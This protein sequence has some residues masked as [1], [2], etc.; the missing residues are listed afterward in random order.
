MHKI[1]KSNMAAEK[2]SRSSFGIAMIRFSHN[3]GA[4]IGLAIIALLILLAIFAPMLTKFPYDRID[5][6]N[7]F[8]SPSW[9]H[10]FG[11][12]DLGRD[13]LSRMMYGGR[14]SL[15]IGV[16][17]VIISAVFGI[18]FGSVAGYFGG[19]LD[20]VIMRF[21][22]ILQSFP[23]ILLAIVI[24]AALGTGYDKAIIALGISGIPV[25]TR[26]MRANI[27]NIRSLEYIE[28]ATSINCSHRRIIMKHVIPNAFSPLIVQLSLS[29]AYSVLA[30]ASLSF[31]GLGV[32]PPLPEWGAMLSA[33][34]SFIR[35]YP[36]LVL[37]P[38]LYIMTCVLAFNIIGDALRDVLDPK[39]KK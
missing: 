1:I 20:N 37:F 35:N 12:D 4:L 26:M 19:H 21:I 8:A 33:G 25:F 23:Q 10:P 18:L 9:E 6:A 14:Y 17:A 24:S 16:F 22:D 32:Q 34:R 28:A 11:T 15:S 31:I 27:L 5:V 2:K 30:A 3:K 38:G 29:L 7:S 13:V 39:L 36:H